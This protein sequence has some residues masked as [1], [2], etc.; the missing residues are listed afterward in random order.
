MSRAFM[1]PEA[2]TAVALETQLEDGMLRFVS[3]RTRNR[4]ADGKLQVSSIFKW[5]A[6]DFEQG[7]LGFKR[8]QDVFARYADAMTS[9]PAERQLLKSAQVPLAY[10]DYDWNLNDLGR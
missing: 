2:F 8:V 4:L 10:L 1:R 9:N 7:H 3:D 5:F 6:Q